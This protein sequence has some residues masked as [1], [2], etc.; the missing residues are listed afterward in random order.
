MAA[1]G[2]AIKEVWGDSGQVLLGE[3]TWRED[4]KNVAWL[5][6]EKHKQTTTYKNGSYYKPQCNQPN[7]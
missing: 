6:Q 3:I 7:V 2:G 1:V 4:V 5:R